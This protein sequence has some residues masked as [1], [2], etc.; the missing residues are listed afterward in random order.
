MSPRPHKRIKS[1]L[2]LKL[3]VWLY[4]KGFWWWRGPITVTSGEPYA[5]CVFETTGWYL[6]G[7]YYYIREKIQYISAVTL[8][9]FFNMLCTW[10]CLSWELSK[11]LRSICSQYSGMNSS[12]TSGVLVTSPAASLQRKRFGVCNKVPTAYYYFCSLT[13][14]NIY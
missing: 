12:W 6:T 2:I 11:E 4:F 7:I 13:T 14:L 3:Q 5:A 10:Q 9:W 1:D 8:G